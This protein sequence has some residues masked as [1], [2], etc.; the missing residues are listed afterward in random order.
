MTL[1]P[2]EFV[3]IGKRAVCRGGRV[4]FALAL[5]LGAVGVR[6]DDAAPAAALQ[7]GR[8][9]GD[10]VPQFY[11]RAV[12][13]P[14]KNKSVCYVCR[15]GDRPVAMVFI[16]EFTPGLSDLLTRLD[17]QIDRNRAEGLR[18]F[19]VLLAEDHRD[20]VSKLQTLAFDHQLSLPL[21]IAPVQVDSP[22]GQNVNPEAAV[23][24]VLYRRRQ[25]IESFAVGSTG[26]TAADVDHIA[27]GVERLLSR[28]EGSGARGQ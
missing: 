16:R 26:L 1:M 27:A 8:A 9:G 22:S 11:V 10:T 21:T 7:S 2:A 12:T 24:V 14:L 3:A 15:N 18:G 28:G 20:S 13:G 19:G 5:T 23:T 17:Q 25:V 4:F 6:G